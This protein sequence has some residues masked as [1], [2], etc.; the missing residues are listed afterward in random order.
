MYCETGMLQWYKEIL[1]FLHEI[2]APLRQY[3]EV[4]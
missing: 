4:M 1:Q 3:S 2:G